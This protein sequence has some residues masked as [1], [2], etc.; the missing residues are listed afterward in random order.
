MGGGDNPSSVTNPVPSSVLDV[1]QGWGG[2]PVLS[3]VLSGGGEV[4]NLGH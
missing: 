4:P 1:A 3:L 2:T